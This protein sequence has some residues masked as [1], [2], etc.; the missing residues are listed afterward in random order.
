MFF[1]PRS[2]IYWYDIVS[3]EL[4]EEARYWGA[5][6]LYGFISMVCIITIIYI[7]W[8]FYIQILKV[9][10]LDSFYFLNHK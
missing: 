10:A 7:M 2:T 6:G 4:A 5:F 9:H 1:L 8:H 3:Q